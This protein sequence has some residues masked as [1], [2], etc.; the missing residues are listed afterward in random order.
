LAR[1]LRLET[2]AEWVTS[3]QDAAI[4][5]NYGIDFFQGHYFGRPDVYPPWGKTKPVIAAA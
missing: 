3:E 5:E 2:V 1:N 4:L